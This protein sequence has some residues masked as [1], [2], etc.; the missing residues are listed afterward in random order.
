MKLSRADKKRRKLAKAVEMKLDGVKLLYGWRGMSYEELCRHHE[1]E[2]SL[3]RNAAT[4]F[5]GTSLADMVLNQQAKAIQVGMD[6][7]ILEELHGELSR[8]S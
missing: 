2:M 4:S 3:R 7:A 5:Y 8:P 1:Y 6:K